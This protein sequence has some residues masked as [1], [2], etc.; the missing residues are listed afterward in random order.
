MS[1]LSSILRPTA[2]HLVALALIAVAATPWLA[3]AESPASWITVFGAVGG[4]TLVS[5]VLTRLW[6]VPLRIELAV[7]AVA[8]VLFLLLAV[9]R[10]PLGVADLARGLRD[11]LP[12]LLSTTLPILEAPW[13]SVPGVMTIWAGAA[14]VTSVVARS[15]SIAVPPGVA[16]AVFV[17]GYLATLSGQS[18]DLTLVGGTEALVLALLMCLLAGLR[19]DQG[20]PEGQRLRAAGRVAL[21]GAIVV[22]SVGIAAAAVAYAPYVPEEPVAPRL[23]T[24]ATPREPTDPLLVTRTLRGDDPDTPVGTVTVDGDWSGYVP[25]AVMD[26]FDGRVWGLTQR[27]FVPTGGTLPVELPVGGGGDATFEGVDIEATGGWLPFVARPS[28]V[29]GTSV[30]HNGGAALQAAEPAEEVGYHLRLSQRPSVITDEDLDG[31]EVVARGAV[32]PLTIADPPGEQRTA[33]ERL[34]RLVAVARDPAAE[35]AIH[36]APCGRIGP[37]DVEFLRALS[38]ILQDGRSVPDDLVGGLQL[39]TGSESLSDLLHLVSQTGTPA[40]VGTPEQF[41]S[42]YALIAAHYGLPARVVTGFRLDPAPADDPATLTGA[43]AWTWVEVPVED[44]GW[45]IVDPSPATQ[46][47]VE[48]DELEA[49]EGAEDERQGAEQ[50]RSVVAVDSSQVVGRPPPPESRGWADIV[51]L[52]VGIPVG[53]VVVTALVAAVRRFVRRRRRRD[54]DARRRVIGAWH[55]VLDGLYDAGHRDVEVLSADDLVGEVASRAPNAAEPLPRLAEVANR[56]IF[57]TRPLSDEEADQWWAAARTVRSGLRRSATY[58]RRLVALLLPAPVDL[59]G[60][61]D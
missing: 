8:L 11:G 12:T 59:T 17:A 23:S 9:L 32:L 24:P 10:N 13:T 37:N 21:A 26:D 57:S 43:Q 39:E 34:C 44:V 53:I 49:P 46:E 14:I 31:T 48:E 6:R 5:L 2:E 7:S 47:E 3:V 61:A 30:L 33:G 20:L 42:V 27:T 28:A 58:R 41:A 25:L 15:R 35:R 60:P 18:G 19:T 22:G 38:L 51:I 52:A 36:D 54:G 50:E 1:R 56:A 4:A 45:V 16:L 29:S 40:A 55:E